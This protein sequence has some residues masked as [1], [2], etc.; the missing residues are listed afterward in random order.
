[1]TTKRQHT[2]GN[3]VSARGERAILPWDEEG[4]SLDYWTTRLGKGMEGGGR[5][6]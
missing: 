6:G 3:E 1:V 5:K 2:K 4:L